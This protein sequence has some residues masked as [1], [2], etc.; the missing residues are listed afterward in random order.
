MKLIIHRG[1]HEVGGNCVELQSGSTRLI[2]D[3]GM[4]LFKRAGEAWDSSLLRSQSKED[5]LDMEILPAVA[6]LFGAGSKIDAILL[7][8]AHEDHTGLLKHT[9]PDIPIFATAGT[10]KMMNAGS[11]FAGQPSLPRER[12]QALTPGI[13]VQI[14]AFKVTPLAVDHS[15]HGCVGFLIEAEG[16]TVLYSGDLRMHGRKSGMM[17]D[18]LH[19]VS[20][21][22]IDLLLMEGTHIQH[23][24]MKRQTEYELEQELLE[25]VNA[26]PGLV[27]A[28]FS[29]QHLDR[30]VAFIRTAI[31]SNRIFVPDVYTAYV[32]YLVESEVSIPSPAASDNVRVFFPKFFRERSQRRKGLQKVTSLFAARRIDLSEIAENPSGYLMIFRPS[33]LASDF[34]AKLPNESRCIFSRWQGYVETPDWQAVIHALSACGGDLVQAHT[35]GHISAEDLV[36]FVG[37]INPDRLI[38]IHT[39]EPERFRD[40][41]PK[42][43][44][45]ADGDEILV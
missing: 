43:L 1:T 11:I 42:V 22:K 29:P 6:G 33:M 41:F 36:E 28:S 10:S 15:I 35:S 34:G 16:K 25:H 21:R 5:L 17:R 39:F 19:A 4:P 24:G 38:P 7:S 26:A 9:N 37:Q 32:M 13:G 44:E 27:L 40:F 3:L 14:G 20:E 8:H 12:H 45:P 31:A 23:V 30:L 18:F 2:V